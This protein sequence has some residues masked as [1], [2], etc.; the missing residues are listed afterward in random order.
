MFVV[1]F[2]V[3]FETLDEVLNMILLAFVLSF[4]REHQNQSSRFEQNKQKWISSFIK[5]S[6]YNK[7]LFI[8]IMLD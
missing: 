5:F 4:L 6:S 1:L 8:N 2:D 3:L 7:E